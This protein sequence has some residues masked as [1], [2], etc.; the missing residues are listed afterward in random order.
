MMRLGL[1]M[2]KA[3]SASQ[4]AT[5]YSFMIAHTVMALITEI[6]INSA[7]ILMTEDLSVYVH[8]AERME[9]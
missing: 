6:S 1:L 8:H 4:G 5:S 3:S 2:S 9:T 7:S